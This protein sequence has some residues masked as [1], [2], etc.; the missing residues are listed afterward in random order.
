[1]YFHACFEGATHG[2]V[3]GLKENGIGGIGEDGGP[4]L[5]G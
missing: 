4:D 2:A 3:A 1:M 5:G